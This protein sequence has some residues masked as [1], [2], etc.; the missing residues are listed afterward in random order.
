MIQ[1]Y[2]SYKY[3]IYSAVLSSIFLKE[4]LS[5]QGKIGCLQCILGAIVI[6][7][8]APEQSSADT[9]IEAF[10]HL[11]LSV[12]MRITYIKIALNRY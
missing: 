2:S 12:G 1:I 5:F 6:V 10:K 7:L 4:R 9:T 3:S 8:H 11:V